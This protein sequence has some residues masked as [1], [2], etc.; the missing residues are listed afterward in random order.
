MDMKEKSWSLR[1]R[2]RWRQGSI[3][4]LNVKLLFFAILIILP[5]FSACAKDAQSPKPPIVLPFAVEKAGNKVETEMRIV[6]HREYT[7]SLQFSYKEGDQADRARVKRLV[8][9][10]MQDKNGDPGI[11]TPLK[12]KVSVIE[13]AGGRVIVDKEIQKLRLRSWGGDSFDKH[14]DYIK[15]EPGHYRVSIESLQDAPD[16]TGIPVALVISANKPK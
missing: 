8:G 3:R 11:P 13:P 12:L 5:W 15:L 7:F 4:L 14:I 9:D 6:E 1:K 10:D 16:L 2:G